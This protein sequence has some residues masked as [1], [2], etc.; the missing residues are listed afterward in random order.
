MIWKYRAADAAGRESA[1]ELTAGTEEEVRTALRGRGLWLISLTAAGTDRERQPTRP[2]SGRL[3]DRIARRSGQSAVDLV[4]TTRALATLL[5]A[6]M[7]VD[8]ALHAAIETATP[9][10]A[11]TLRR[12]QQRIRQGR[13]LAEATADVGLPPLF[14][15]MLAAAEASGSLAPTVDRLAAHLERDAATHARLRATLVYP[16]VLA[17]SSIGGTLVILTV[18][19]PR[20]A[21]LLGDA[22]AALPWSTRLLLAFSRFVVGG[23]WLLLPAAGVLFAWWRQRLRRPEYRLAWDRQRLAW[24]VL[25][26]F[27]QQRDMARYLATLALGLSSGVS[28]LRSMQL[29]R[30]T[31]TNRALA[32]ALLPA[33][34]QVRDGRGVAES[35]APVLPVLARPLLAAGEASGALAEMASRAADAA[36]AAAQQRVSQLLSLIEP[37]LILGFG[38]IVGFVALA[39]LQAIYGMNAGA[40]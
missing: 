34:Q 22:G 15:P 32:E 6:G 33:E 13:S 3:I 26:A 5:S 23:G 11:A 12:V 10:W 9:A 24:P 21:A 1:G 18:V 36:E 29:A 8:R 4:V 19:V 27:E 37:V 2:H 25:G 14:S 30:Q 20:F 35:L 38:G 16:A 28:L 17:L 7:P 39:L 31:A 40:F